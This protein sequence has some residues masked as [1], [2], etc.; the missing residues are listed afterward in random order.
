MYV[1][2]AAQKPSKIQA[3]KMPLDG[4]VT[5]DMGKAS[6]G[7]S[8]RYTPDCAGVSREWSVRKERMYTASLF[9]KFDHKDVVARGGPGVQVCFYKME[10]CEFVY[11]LRGK[12]INQVEDTGNKII[13]GW[14]LQVG[15]G[16]G[17]Q[18]PYR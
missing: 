12:E 17:I 11:V 6:S 7:Q 4:Q 2:D 1:S 18:S 14:G 5:G 13:D 8:C 10:G 16:D 9:Q 15:V 3:E